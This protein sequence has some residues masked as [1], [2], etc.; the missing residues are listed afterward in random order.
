MGLKEASFDWA[1]AHVQK[2]GDTDLF[3]VPFEYDAIKGLWR[4]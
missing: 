3:P 4:W 2:Y 1:L